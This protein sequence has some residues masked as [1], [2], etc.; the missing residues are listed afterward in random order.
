M[1]LFGGTGRAA[2]L[3]YGKTPLGWHFFNTEGKTYP[4]AFSVRLFWLQGKEAI[5]EAVSRCILLFFFFLE[6]KS[7][8]ARL[9]SSAS[10]F[11][12]SFFKFHPPFYSFELF[13][14]R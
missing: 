7:P 12:V 2:T 9:L 6:V 5:S 3:T 1:G 14:S 11:H 13:E 8:Q 10:H 4:A